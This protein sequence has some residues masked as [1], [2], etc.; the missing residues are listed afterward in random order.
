M[1]HKV[2]GL[3]RAAARPNCKSERH[4]GCVQRHLES[5]VMMLNQW[6]LAFLHRLV[7]LGGFISVPDGVVNQELI[8]LIEAD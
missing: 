7:E 5:V 3:S 8:E 6:Q 4:L 2:F 1:V